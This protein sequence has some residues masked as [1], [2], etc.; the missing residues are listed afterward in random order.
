[1]IEELKL[2]RLSFLEVLIFFLKKKSKKGP[3]NTLNSITHRMPPFFITSTYLCFRSLYRIYI[4]KQGQSWKTKTPLLPPSTF[5]PGWEKKKNFTAHMGPIHYFA[6]FKFSFF[7]F[8]FIQT[9]KSY[10][11]LS[12]FFSFPLLPSKISPT[13]HTIRENISIN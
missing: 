13:K 1:M 3:H 8:P 4:R 11:F 7:I 12:Y 5:P 10:S 2:F 9:R 6:L